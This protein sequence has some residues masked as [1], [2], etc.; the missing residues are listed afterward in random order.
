MGAVAAS[1]IVEINRCK[2][3]PDGTLLPDPQDT[4]G[5]VEC[6]GGQETYLKCDD[7]LYWDQGMQKCDESK[8]CRPPQYW[9][10]YQYGYQDGIYYLTDISQTNPFTP[11]TGRV[12][13][14]ILGSKLAM[15]FN[16]SEYK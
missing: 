14:Q 15:P 4:Q 7:D 9:S 3:Q 2:N 10:N 1:P 16:E 11:F 5:Y 12:L 6:Q 8:A 13:C